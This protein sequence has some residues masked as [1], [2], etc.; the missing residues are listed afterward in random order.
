MVNFS[1]VILEYTTSDSLIKCE[2]KWMDLLKPEYNLNPK[3][4]NSKGYIHTPESI[5]MMRS[6]ALGRKHSDQVKNLM[7]ES[8]GGVNNSFY[9]KK[10]T[11]EALS[12]LRDTALNRTKLSKPGVEV[13]VT[14][15]ETKLTSTYES[16]R[17]AA[18]AINSDIKSLSLIPLISRREIRGIREKS[19]LEKGINTPYR[20]RYIIAARDRKIR[21]FSVSNSFNTNPLSNS[22]SS[23]SSNSSSSQEASAHENEGVSDN[24]NR[25]VSDNESG[26]SSDSNRSAVSESR[27]DYALNHMPTQDVPED[28]LPRF[29][30]T[31][32]LVARES[33]GDPDIGQLHADRYQALKTEMDSRIEAG[34]MPRPNVGQVNIYSENGGPET[35]SGGSAENKVGTETSSGGGTNNVGTSSLSSF[36]SSNKRKNDETEEYSGQPSKKFQQD[37][38]DIRSDT[39]PYDFTGGDE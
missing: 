31:M 23:S 22:L 5:E 24:E 14:D 3:A 4:V 34:I 16:I 11:A 32:E 2:Q 35:S 39:E 17:K 15:L 6:L 28:V 36:Y 18:K 1:L 20:G 37:S 19:Q 27:D 21:E 9:G 12:L 29:V 7:S 38:S 26:Y 8:R 30:S 10:H 13:V 25:E 33:E